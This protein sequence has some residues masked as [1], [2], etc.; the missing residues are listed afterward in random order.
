MPDHR[1]A[2][3]KTAQEGPSTAPGIDHNCSGTFHRH[4]ELGLRAHRRLKGAPDGEPTY[5][6]CPDCAAIVNAAHATS[7]T[8]SANEHRVIPCRISVHPRLCLCANSASIMCFHPRASATSPTPWKLIAAAHRVHAPHLQFDHSS[9]AVS[10]LPAADS[11]DTWPWSLVRPANAPKSDPA[12][13]PPPR[14]WLVWTRY[15]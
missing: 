14:L 10:D 13:N 8:T 3:C 11:L 1:A 7:E 12:D 9:D 5:T 15:P 4:A 2:I 6:R